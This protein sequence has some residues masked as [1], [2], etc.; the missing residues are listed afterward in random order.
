MRLEFRLWPVHGE[1][2]TLWQD[3]GLPVAA[4]SDSASTL[5]G[6]Q[7]SNGAAAQSQIAKSEKDP[8]TSGT[9]AEFVLAQARLFDPFGHSVRRRP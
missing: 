6:Q 4:V 1:S 8:F 9:S 5:Q 2:E 7:R 3:S